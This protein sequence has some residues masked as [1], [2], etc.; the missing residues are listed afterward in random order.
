MQS[1]PVALSSIW[2]EQNV[3]TVY[4]Y[5]MGGL[6][7]KEDIHYS[8]GIDSFKSFGE[9]KEKNAARGRRLIQEV[10]L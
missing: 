2:I 5:P 8:E 6:H 1:R 10:E 7:C 3:S 9:V 4:N